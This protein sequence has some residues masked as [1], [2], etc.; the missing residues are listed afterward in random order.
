MENNLLN[1]SLKILNIFENNVNIINDEPIKQINFSLEKFLLDLKNNSTI[2]NSYLETE[3]FNKDEINDDEILNQINNKKKNYFINNNIYNSQNDFVKSDEENKNDLNHN[4]IFNTKQFKKLPRKNSYKNNK[5][6][7]NSEIN[8]NIIE[9]KK[10]NYTHRSFSNLMRINNNMKRNKLF[11]NLNIYKRINNNYMD[12]YININKYNSI[13]EK[14][15]QI[16]N[17]NENNKNEIL[18]YKKN[19]NKMFTTIIDRISKKEFQLNMAHQ[20][21]IFKMINEIN[22]YK[23]KMNEI[24]N[25]NK[26]NMNDYIHKLKG[27][28]NQNKIKKEEIKNKYEKLIKDLEK[29]KDNLIQ[30]KKIYCERFDEL[31]ETN[32]KLNNEINSLNKEKELLNEENNKLKE[33]INELKNNSENI[34]KTNKEQIENI[35]IENDN[36]IN[37]LKEE[38]D[39]LKNEINDKDSELIES[40]TK[41]EE[42]KNYMKD[43][44]IALKTHEKNIQKINEIEK[45]LIE[46]KNKNNEMKLKNNSILIENEKLK[47]EIELIK[48]EKN[49]LH[50]ENNLKRDLLEKY[51]RLNNDL[52]KEKEE[53][54]INIKRLNDKIIELKNK[55]ERIIQMNRIMSPEKVHKLKGDFNSVKKEKR[56]LEEEYKEL[57]KRVNLKEKMNRVNKAL[58]GKEKEDIINEQDE[59]NESNESNDDLKDKIIKRDIFLLSDIIEKSK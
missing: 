43:A 51:K 39:K 53:L 17:S 14:I 18:N 2:I 50:K 44:K 23:N 11:N 29:A 56:K 59:Y 3:V 9:D 40:K 16:K 12:N 37:I 24:L 58:L 54:K 19:F 57:L 15:R 26:K 6:I 4:Y 8:N 7:I 30:D 21:Q 42:L 22:S 35:N 41:I 45:E 38:I 46:Y 13:L 27:I 49:Q 1:D 34:N 31:K 48:N 20:N 5:N 47:N 28:I 36:K 25:I 52:N 55:N 33:Q 10:R 32:T